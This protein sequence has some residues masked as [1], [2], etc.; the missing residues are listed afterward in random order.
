MAGSWLG[1]EA[2]SAGGWW[3]R[4]GAG[5]RPATSTSP[6]DL[7]HQSPRRGPLGNIPR[8]LNYI[9]IIQ[10]AIFTSDT[11]NPF[12]VWILRMSCDS[13]HSA[14]VFLRM[15]VN[16]KRTD[17]WWLEKREIYKES[18]N[19]NNCKIGRTI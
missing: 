15:T 14:F 19:F 2:G 1:V 4:G 16:V 6:P 12:S 11:T 10:H 8:R 7:H 5:L 13:V 18:F 3:H 9:I 17:S